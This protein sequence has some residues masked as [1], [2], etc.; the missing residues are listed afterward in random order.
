[1][2]LEPASFLKAAQAAAGRKRNVEFIFFT[3]SGRQ[4]D[5]KIAQEY[6]DKAT[7]SKNFHM[8][9][10]CGRYEGID[11]R[12]PEILNAKPLSIGP[13][14]LSGGELPAAVLVDA[15]SR[16][17]PG[18]LGDD[19]SIEERRVASSKVY[20]RPETLKWKGKEYKVPEVLKSGDHK[21]IEL[22]RKEN[23]TY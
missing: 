3:P 2:V 4:F 18:V 15:I 10:L 14:V 5:N 11:A 20:T 6:A 22:W 8:I 1:M 19:M 9:M 12:V 21:K 7:N 23:S 17:L 16:R 13:Y